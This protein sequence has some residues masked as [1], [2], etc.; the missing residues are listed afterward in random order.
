M[1]MN[2]D[3]KL[4]TFT[5]LYCALDE[6]NSNTEKITL[7]KQFFAE[8]SPLEIQWGLF[9]LSGGK[10]KRLLTST[11]LRELAAKVSGLPLWLIEES[12]QLVGDLAETVSLT[13]PP[14]CKDAGDTHPHDHSPDNNSSKNAPNNYLFEWG[15]RLIQLH[16]VP[17]EV[18]IGSITSLMKELTRDEILVFCKLLTGGLRIGVAKSTVI[19]ALSQHYSLDEGN[20]AYRLAGKTKI[21]EFDLDSILSTTELDRMNTLAP[22]PFALAHPLPLKI[23]EASSLSPSW[24]ELGA[25][26]DWIAEWKWDGIRAQIVTRANGIAIWSRG[27]EVISE[28]FPELCEL[29]SLLP[30]DTV[31]DGEIVAFDSTNKTSLRSHTFNIA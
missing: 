26:T 8:S 5:D 18:R 1:D 31:L 6:T 12:Y 29:R 15:Q 21:E 7:L 3:K 22:Y 17:E 10:I 23:Q 4:I 30:E 16:N 20:I 28:S 14:L 24:E 27:E 19:K 9:L 11:Q 2:S 25:P 13:L